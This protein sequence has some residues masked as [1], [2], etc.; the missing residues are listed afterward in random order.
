MR[1]S[2]ANTVT[3][4][5]CTAVQRRHR[6]RSWVEGLKVVAL[7]SALFVVLASGIKWLFPGVTWEAGATAVVLWCVAVVCIMIFFRDA[8]P[9]PPLESGSIASPSHGTI[10]YIDTAEETHVF[11][12]TARRISIYLSLRNV[13]VQHAPVAA[14]VSTVKHFPGRW[15]RA[16]RREA[17]LRNEHLLVGLILDDGSKM[18]LRMISGIVVRRIVPWIVPGQQVLCGERI[19]LIRFGSRVDVFVPLD[20]QVTVSPGDKVR[21]GT[22]TIAR[23]PS[24]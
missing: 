13:H 5:D 22:T 23:P 16:I 6:G 2:I 15:S 4:T 24:S 3:S 18:A 20:W 21:G 11:G 17:S 8:D 19:G 9:S 14:R 7:V 10:D 1:E 12:G